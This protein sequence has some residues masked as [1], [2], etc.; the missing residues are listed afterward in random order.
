MPGG[1]GGDLVMLLILL[2]E[3]VVTGIFEVGNFLLISGIGV[4]RVWL[5]RGRI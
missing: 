1:V 3:I 2:S 5:S 4:F